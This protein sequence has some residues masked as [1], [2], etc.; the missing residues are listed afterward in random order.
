MKDELQ[1]KAT[2]LSRDIARGT[3]SVVGTTM[4]IVKWALVLTLIV[5]VLVGWF[6][7][8]ANYSEGSRSGR[9]IKISRKGVVFKTWEGQM[10]VGGISTPGAPGQITSMWEFTVPADEAELLERL[11]QL[12]VRLVRAAS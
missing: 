4:R 9:L 6:L 11:D 2:E 8:T 5:S 10:D 12:S 1:Q 7:Y 3:R